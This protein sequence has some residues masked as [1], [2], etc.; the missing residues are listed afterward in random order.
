MASPSGEEER[1]AGGLAESTT[2][3]KRAV[4]SDERNSSMVLKFLRKPGTVVLP[5][6]AAE[7]AFLDGGKEGA[8]GSGALFCLRGRGRWKLM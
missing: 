3:W 4:L 7:A 8:T 2:D 5:G 1:E 6:G